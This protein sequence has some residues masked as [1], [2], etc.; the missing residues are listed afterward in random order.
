MLH[1]W[2]A[3]AI[4]TLALQWGVV[5]LAMARD[6]LTTD[7]GEGVSMLNRRI[8]RTETI[9]SDIALRLAEMVFVRVYGKEYTEARSPLVIID[10]GDRWDI[11]SRE[12]IA[13]GERLQIVI[14]KS[15]ARILELTNF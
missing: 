5:E 10:R 6:P 12:G 4:V 9:S 11:R 3:S 13:P 8:T 15:N 1:Q 14:V 2:A 7:E